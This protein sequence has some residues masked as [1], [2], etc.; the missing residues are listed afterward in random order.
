V[1]K[2]A[3]A[4]SIPRHPTARPCLETLEDRCLLSINA[5]THVAGPNIDVSNLAGYQGE[6]TIAIN[7]TNP[8]NMI[9]GSNNLGPSSIL[10]VTEAYWTKDGGNTWTAVDLGGEGD[11]GV[12]FDRAGNAYFSF[13][14]SNFG[15][16]VRKSTDGGVSWAPAVQVASSPITNGLEDKPAIAVGPDHTNNATDRVYVGWDDEGAGDV[17]QVSSSGDGGATWTAP[18][19][20]D[21]QRSEIYAQPAVGPDGTLYI[22]WDNFATRN[23]SS[24][25]FS[26]STDN[27]A[28]FSTP[29]V[30]ATSTINLFN[31]TG[32]GRYY[33][34][35]QP[36]RGIAADPSLAVEQSG[37]NAG[38]IY[39][40]YTSAPTSHD[41]TNIYVIASDTGGASWTALGSS[42][43]QVNDDHTSNSQF[44][45]AV[46]IDPT[47]G[48]VN[49]A[50]YDARNDHKNQKVDVYFQSYDSAGVASGANVKV[51]TATS[52]E[53]NLR[54]NNP[55][56]YGD[57]MGIAASGGFAFPVWTDHRT[58]KSGTEEI[59]V[60]P[61]LPIPGVVDPTAPAA[62]P[63]QA[64]AASFL[65]GTGTSTALGTVPLADLLVWWSPNVNTGQ[66]ANT[67][68]SGLAVP[69]QVPSLGDGSIEAT[70]P[71][72]SNPSRAAAS[73]EPSWD[74]ATLT[75]PSQAQP[76]D[77]LD[78]LFAQ[79]DAALSLDG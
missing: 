38:R 31:T 59:Y 71:M 13:I 68:A 53:S 36:T 35:A 12:A 2:N 39:L 54:T 48:T 52:D 11:P 14:D 58:N 29:V 4:R 22:A 34:P 50:W 28:T 32:T 5:T 26:R 27:G 78:R 30:A 23:Q 17:L 18:I 74:A 55:N 51:T 64:A 57:Y 46:A 25:M 16:S 66:I 60:D 49:L 21:G 9:A 76:V 56:Q 69:P 70:T 63:Q 62:A 37:P 67:V 72:T 44:F 19:S 20:V 42:A 65:A 1:S 10:G 75:A 7:P 61:P 43:V 79:L 45:S 40:T 6:T 77:L 24:I 3:S 15:I 33:I 41:D 47:N 8:A 73:A